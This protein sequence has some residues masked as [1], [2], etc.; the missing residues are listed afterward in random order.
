MGAPCAVCGERGAVG[1]PHRASKES[2]FGRS[3]QGVITGPVA[4]ATVTHCVIISRVAYLNGEDLFQASH[5]DTALVVSIDIIPS[6]MTCTSS[7]CSLWSVNSSRSSSTSV[8]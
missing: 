8:R 5:V 1:Q 2:I 3:F 7:A 6:F 4:A